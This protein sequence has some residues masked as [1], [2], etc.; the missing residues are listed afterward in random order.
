MK[1]DAANSQK[2]QSILE[3][4]EACSGQKVNKDKSSIMFSRNVPTHLREELKQRLQLSMEARTKKYLGL[5]IYI[6]R[7]KQNSFENLKEKIWKRI[8]GWR[9]KLLSMAGKEILIKA[10]AQAIPTYAMACFDLTKRFCDQV[11]A[12]I[13]RY[14]WSQQDRDKMHWLPYLMKQVKY[15]GGM[16]F[17]DLYA[18]NIVMLA[19]QGWRLLHNPD[20]LCGQILR[21]GYFPDGNILH[22]KANVGISYTWCSILKGI[23][24]IKKGMIWR[25]GNGRSVHIW[26]DPWIPR[27]VTRLPCSHRGQNLIQWV[28]D[29]I[30]PITGT[31]DEELIRQIFHQDDVQTILAISVHED[32]DGMVGWHFDTKGKFSVK[33]AYKAYIDD[34]SDRQGTSSGSPHH[35]AAGGS[36]PW[37]KIWKMGCPN[38]VN[39]FAWRLIHN[40]L[41]LK[42]KIEARGIELDTRYPVCWRVDEDACHLLFKCK[43]SKFVWRELHLDQVRMHLA[44]LS[45]PKEVFHYI[46]GC[47]NELQVKIITLM[48]VLTSERNAVNTSER[49]KR[50]SQVAMQTQRY[51]MEFRDFFMRRSDMKLADQKR[52]A[53]PRPDFMKVNVDASFREGVM[54]GGWG[55]VARNEAREIE[56]VGAGNI[57]AVSSSLQAEAIACLQA[58]SCIAQQGMMAIELETDYLNLKNT[59]RSNDW[60]ATP[61]G[62]LI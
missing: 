35:S 48:W 10:V 61:E 8:Q 20:S 17:R 62:M 50:A 56:C 41:P 47:A 28:S 58:L 9:E 44:V 29:L 15:A 57:N 40:S 34:V 21:V 22:A 23:E 38:K 36:F 19:K 27:G 32:L 1:A 3:L 37:H 13:S 59:L 42:R 14:W 25:V 12:M 31:R 2:L 16:G 11:R 54:T 53:K 30:D 6:G 45:S 5:P 26:K 52:W 4:Y 18:F 60:D 43:F 55:F 7:S 51:Y 49:M 24:L 39:L 33:S 46:W